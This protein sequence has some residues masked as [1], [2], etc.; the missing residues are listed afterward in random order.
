MQSKMERSKRSAGVFGK[1]LALLMVVST[2]LSACTVAPGMRMPERAGDA[3]N[4]GVQ[5][6]QVP[7][8]EINPALIRRLRDDAARSHESAGVELFTASKAYTLGVGDVLQIIVWDHPE[9]AAA[10]GAQSAAQA[11]PAD[12]PTG[13]VVDQSGNV[14]FPYAGDVR[15][16]G[17][18]VEQFRA[19][20]VQQLS[21]VY[22]NP[23]VTVRVA[24]FRAKQTYIDGEVR[25][26]G[27]QSINDKPMTL[28]EAI[29]RAGG[30][31]AQADQSRMVL[32]RDGVSHS[33]N[34]SDMLRYKQDP[35]RIVLK[36]GDL[37]RVQ[38]RD[39]SGV[40]VMG[41]INKP[42]TALP[43]RNGKLTLS[44]ALSQGGSLNA[45]SSDAAKVY[46]V[47]GATEHTPRVYRLDASSPVSMVL[48]NQFELQ[49]NDVVY[50]D[51]TGL[52]RASRVLIQLLPAINAGLTGI[53]VAK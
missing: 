3:M 29:G 12:A 26:P 6:P 51:S 17:L 47:R 50:V 53:V 38:S 7:F 16:V 35:S 28:L 19:R 34:L 39:E 24:S 46:V 44:D 37:L 43:M 8:D 41:E 25:S 9:L 15:A 5:A 30:F 27:A 21:R 52:A 13:F 10:Q 14:Q 23:Q 42:V 33:L 49:P 32:V 11:R 22:R 20:L 48:A 36:D 40:F 4:G 2:M 45:A 1:G 31:S 18:D